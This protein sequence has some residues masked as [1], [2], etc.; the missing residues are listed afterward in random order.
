MGMEEE[1]TKSTTSLQSDSKIVDIML[2]SIAN[3]M[4]RGV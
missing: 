3:C 4:A 1:F 2:L